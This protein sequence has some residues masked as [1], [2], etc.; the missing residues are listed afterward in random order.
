MIAEPIDFPVIFKQFP[1]I[2]AGQSTRLGGKE[3][4]FG[5]FNLGE[6]VGDEQA[7]VDQNRTIFCEML[8]FVP[9]SLAKSKQVHGTEIMYATAPGRYEGYDA[10]YTDKKGVLVA[11]TIADCVPILIYD[12]HNQVVA[13]I[14]AGWKGSCDKIVTKYVDILK[15]QFKSKSSDLYA[16]IGTC[17][18]GPSYE[19]DWDVAQ[20][21]DELYRPYDIS[22]SKYFLDL[23]LQNYDQLIALGV[24]SS[25]I[26]RSKFCTLINKDQFYSHRGDHGQSGRM[27]AAIGLLD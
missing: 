10:L 15:S 17:I 14:H 18:S 21:F 9:N 25:Q 4:K 3:S 27:L 5:S 12:A 23:S 7:I 2:I 22:R 11:V 16:Y 19:V 26:E 1:N 24:P 13:A 6:S 8:G 20:Y